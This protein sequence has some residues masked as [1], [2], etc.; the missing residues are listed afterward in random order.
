MKKHICVQANHH[1]DVG[2]TIE[3]YELEGWHFLNYKPV[4]KTSGGF[5]WFSSD[6][7]HYLLFEKEEL[8]TTSKEEETAATTKPKF[9]KIVG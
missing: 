4:S 6:I 7:V 3:K 5:W 9:E 1:K 2:P 8:A